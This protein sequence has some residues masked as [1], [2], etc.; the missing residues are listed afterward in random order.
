MHL[1]DVVETVFCSLAI[2]NVGDYVAHW[3]HGA[4]KCLQERQAFLFCTDLT[5]QTA[6]VFAAF[7]EDSGYLFEEWIMPHVAFTVG[8]REIVPVSQDDMVRSGDDTSSWWVDEAA[9]AD[10]VKAT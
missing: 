8:A 6:C 9:I 10:F 2:W 3:R 1:G 4:S 5:D 7:P